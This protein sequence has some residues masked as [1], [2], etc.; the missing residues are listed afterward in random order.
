VA[1]IEYNLP[2]E[3]LAEERSEYGFYR[4]GL[5]TTPGD[6]GYT[7]SR[8]WSE[9]N[10]RQYVARPIQMLHTGD[11]LKNIKR[12]IER[13]NIGTSPFWIKEQITGDHFNVP[14]GPS[15]D[16]SR[17]CF[18]VPFYGSIT[19]GIYM[20]DGVPQFSGYTVHS[21]A[22]LLASD[23]AAIPTAAKATIVNGAG[24][25]QSNF[26][27]VSPGCLK[28]VPDTVSTCDA[29]L[30]STSDMAP[31][32]VGNDY[33]AIIAVF[34]TKSTPRNF[35]PGIRW[36]TAG[37]SFVSASNLLVLGTTEVGWNIFSYTATA[38]A[39]AAFAS[40]HISEP[41]ASTTPWFTGAMSIAPAS[42]DRW[43]LPSF[44]PNV[45]EFS[46]AVAAYGR[47]TASG[48]GFGMARCVGGETQLLMEMMS[49]GHAAPNR[50]T[51]REEIEI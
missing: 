3:V 28:V 12:F 13:T 33:T 17:T 10:L 22:N 36:Y 46:S 27:I 5:V 1:Q 44:A 4:P 50:L 8:V 6:F 15:G 30:T 32:V 45:L 43:H 48:S 41:G 40:P 20:I 42:Y 49:P 26:G 21:A 34:E 31:V 2:P 37:G 39:T 25:D 19:N 7:L 18:P 51:L 24:S 29:Y 23:D 11:G 9:M 47:V 16:A 35:T 14:C 38:V